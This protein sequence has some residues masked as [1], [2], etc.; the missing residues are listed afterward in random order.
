[1]LATY[2]RDGVNV[3]GSNYYILSFPE[4]KGGQ[5]RHRGSGREGRRPPSECVGDRLL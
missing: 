2:Y 1:M 3:T 5:E 4:T